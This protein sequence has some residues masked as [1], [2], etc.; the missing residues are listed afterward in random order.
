MEEQNRIETY[1]DQESTYETYS[2][3]LSRAGLKEA[4]ES[5]VGYYVRR[6]MDREL[7]PGGFAAAIRSEFGTTDDVAL[8]IA[9]DVA[10]RILTAIKTDLPFGLDE[11]IHSE[12]TVTSMASNDGAKASVNAVADTPLD[13]E[14]EQIKQTRSDV[15]GTKGPLDI[16]GVVKE[17]CENPTFAFDDPSLQA[18]CAKLIESRVRDVRTP[19]QTRTQLEKSVD[20][21][22]LGVTGRRLSDMLA[23]IEGRVAAYQGNVSQEEQR[24]RDAQRAAKPDKAAFVKQEETLLTK[25]YVALTGK[26]PDAPISPAGPSITR[27]SA[28]LSAHHEQLSREGKIDARKVKE[29]IAGAQP[30]ANASRHHATPSMQEVIF[31]KRL[32]GPID[33]L[34]ALTLTDFRRLSKDAAQAATKVKDKVDLLE[35]QGYDKKVQAVQ[36]WRASPLN[37]MYVALARDA[38]L[39]GTSVAELLAEKHSANVDT[40]SHDELKAVMLINAHVRF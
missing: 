18:R 30:S 3:I 29:V 10:E 5:L 2:D 38:V 32:S 1:L 9:R 25:K 4:D 8:Q 20:N 13:Q 14:L 15:I 17:I 31:E 19:E 33:E 34:R 22:G 6:L 37:Q 11:M 23:L 21:G 12:L 28:A 16:P 36:A 27:T 40:L 24:K 39:A 26:V 35:E 7:A